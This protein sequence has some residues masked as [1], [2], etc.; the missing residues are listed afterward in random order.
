MFTVRWCKFYG[1]SKSQSFLWQAGKLPIESRAGECVQVWRQHTMSQKHGAYSLEPVLGWYENTF[2][3][4]IFIFSASWIKKKTQII[5]NMSETK[6]HS[7][8]K[9]SPD[10]TTHK[11]EWFLEGVWGDL[12]Y[13]MRNTTVHICNTNEHLCSVW[14]HC[15][16]PERSLCSPPSR[17][18]PPRAVLALCR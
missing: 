17:S 7:V 9:V 6:F 13:L 15:L 4:F 8:D 10:D 14:T 11:I 5:K 12:L 18:S 3:Y 1:F 16:Y 2:L